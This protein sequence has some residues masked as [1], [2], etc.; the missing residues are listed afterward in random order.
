[1]AERPLHPDR[2][3]SRPGRVGARFSTLERRVEEALANAGLGR[4]AGG[5][6]VLND[7]LDEALAVLASARRFTASDAFSALRRRIGS[8]RS[9]LESG[10]DERIAR[11]ADTLLQG[12]YRYWW[13]VETVGIE[14]IPASG[15][16][17]LVAN[18]AGTFLPYEAAMI[19]VTIARAHPARRRVRALIDDWAAQLPLLGPTL[20]RAGAVRATPA[21]LRRLL[22]EGEAVVVFPEGLEILAKSFSSRYRLDRFERS[23]FARVAIETACPIVPVAVIGAEET[24]PVLARLDRPAQLLGLRSLPL[25]PTFPWLGV[26]GLL[27]LPTKWTLHVGEPLDVAARHAPGEARERKVVNRLRDQVHERLQALVSEGL[28]RRRS[29]FLG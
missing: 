23:S 15:R 22:A 10:G 26:A 3:A 14:R 9:T 18:R 24:H 21:R 2:A 17:L 27:P 13:R 5:R 8:G 1:M 12:L 16:V 19:P 11:L 20:A 7:V 4:R 6:D 25:T 29:V 28:R